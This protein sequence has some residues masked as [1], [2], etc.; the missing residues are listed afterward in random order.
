MKFRLACTSSAVAALISAPLAA[1]A[2]TDVTLYGLVATAARYA[3]NAAPGGA[4]LYSL[5]D[6]AFTG[7]RLGFKGK[8]DL[9]GGLRAIF[10]LEMGIDPSAGSLTQT[11][12]AASFGNGATGRAFGRESWVGLS[13]ATFGTVQFGRQYTLAHTFSTRFQPLTNPNQDSLSVFSGHH[14]AR[15]DNMAKY[16][17]DMGPFNYAASVT[18]AENSGKAWS[19][20]GGYK[21]GP[22]D[23]VA[24]TEKLHTPDGLDIRKI[25][26]GGGSYAIIPELK[27]YLGYM[28][29][30]QNSTAQENQVATVALSWFVIPLL[31]LTAIYTQDHQTNVLAGNRKVSLLVADYFLSKRTDVYVELD[32]NRLNGSFPLPAFMATR[33]NQK[34]IDFGV[35]HWF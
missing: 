20:A 19:V 3:T 32:Q 24:Y 13:S 34:G 28:R 12:A 9:G 26:G 31:Q 35:R 2:Q 25:W 7:S 8:E 4:R 1:F 15:Q 22:V 30:T 14:V 29:Q 5:N 16:S 27:A 10:A 6:D 21:A 17:N 33:A 11:N 23:I 18:A